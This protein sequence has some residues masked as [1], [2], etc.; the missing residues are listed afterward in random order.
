MKEIV[1]MGKDDQDIGR[2][3]ELNTIIGKGSTFTGD[4]NVQNSLRVDGKVKGNVSCTDTVVVGKEG[5]VE[6]QVKAK[7][8]LL[9]GK[10]SGQIVSTGKVY[11]E[12]KACILGDIKAVRLV[13]DD[14]AVFDGKCI[15]NG[16]NETSKEIEKES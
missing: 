7:N 10:L 2:S 8:V 12:A 15:M 5:E 9:A 11:L 16:K 1:V 6:G 3:G 13:I 4:I 14:G